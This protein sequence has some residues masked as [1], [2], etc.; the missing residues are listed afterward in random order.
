[1]YVHTYIEIIYIYDTFISQK[2]VVGKKNL[3]TI[4]NVI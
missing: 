1:M 4:V 3:N 2:H